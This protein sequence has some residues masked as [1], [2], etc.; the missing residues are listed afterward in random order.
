MLASRH[1]VAD[2]RRA[3]SK[4]MT[5]GKSVLN[6]LSL[7]YLNLGRAMIFV[8]IGLVVFGALLAGLIS[9]RKFE[10][11]RVPFFVYWT[12][13]FAVG[14]VMDL[15]WLNAPAAYTG[16]YLWTLV[17]LVMVVTIAVGYVLGV[18]TMARSRNAWGHP[19]YAALIFVPIANLWLFFK[20]P[21]SPTTADATSVPLTTGWRGI[22][23]GVV[24]IIVGVG[25]TFVTRLESDT[26][27]GDET[28]Q[29]A[30]IDYLIR[31][32]GLERALALMADDVELPLVISESLTLVELNT[33]GTTIRYEYQ[34]DA[35]GDSLLDSFRQSVID[36]LCSNAPMRRILDAGARFEYA[37]YGLDGYAFGT[38]E[39]TAESCLP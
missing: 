19:Y 20:P 34:V 3:V 23:T 24:L 14:K 12:A 32:Q 30:N 10:L 8:S 2:P 33:Y 31:D 39:V 25:V 29:N 37:Y 27:A 11:K 15:V 28:W 6:E 1:A 35:Q 13:L 18:I 17:A 7:D 38:I 21:K 5:K 36:G 22:A 9:R 4:N 16:G 26:V